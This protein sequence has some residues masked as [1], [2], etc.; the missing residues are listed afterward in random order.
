MGPT[1]PAW[2]R[3]QAVPCLLPAP[4]IQYQS[5]GYG[6]LGFFTP[7]SDLIGED[8]GGIQEHELL[9]KLV[10]DSSAGGQGVHW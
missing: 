6:T 7:G 3:C 4:G 1:A 8:C 2:D 10:A 9:N 5:C